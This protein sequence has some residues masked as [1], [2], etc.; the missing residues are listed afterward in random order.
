M[1]QYTAFGVI[2]TNS[3]FAGICSKKIKTAHFHQTMITTPLLS[4]SPSAPVPSPP[5][6]KRTDDVS[7]RVDREPSSLRGCLRDL[8]KDMLAEM[9]DLTPAVWK[10]L[11]LD[12]SGKRILSPLFRV[13][14]LK[15]LG[16]T[17]TLYSSNRLLH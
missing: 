4:K 2:A 10:I 3:I 5:T 8:Q 14:E 7:T 6:L 12:D 11:V 15:E 9:L 1:E 17:L 13:A 16:V